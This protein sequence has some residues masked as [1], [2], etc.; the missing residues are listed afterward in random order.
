MEPGEHEVMGRA[1]ERH[2]W[3]LGLRDLLARVLAR[4]V[5]VPRPRVLDAGCG[6]GANLRLLRDVLHP[7]YLGGFDAEPEALELA[8]AKVPEADL[9]LGDVCDPEVRVDALDLVLSTDV[10]YVPGA[11]RARPG[12]LRLAERLERGGLLV[13]HVPAYR[14]LYSDH[15]VAVHGTQRFT[16][17][18]VRALLSGLG[19]RVELLTYR[20]C[21]LFPLVVASRLPRL[22]RPGAAAAPAR[23]ELHEEPDARVNRALLAVLRLENAAILAGARL[24]FGSSV[25][26]V[27]RKP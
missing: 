10:I 6:T 16:A 15:D 8:R 14:W 24:P 18:E 26:A 3:Y 4:E 11:E 17:R 9:Y 19:L 2:W 22:T 20:L 21:F 5:R 25:F 1:E 13:L 12:L 23:S 27:A 7:A